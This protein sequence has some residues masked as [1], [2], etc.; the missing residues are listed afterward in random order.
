MQ[1][2]LGGLDLLVLVAVAIAV[3]NPVPTA[4]VMV[5]PQKVG[6]FEFDGFLQHELGGQADGFGERSLSGGRAGEL[7]FEGSSGKLAFHVCLSL[8]VLPAQLDSALS[9]FLQ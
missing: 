3:K 8:S 7:F 2:T 9:W 6:E 4:L 1:G 5:A